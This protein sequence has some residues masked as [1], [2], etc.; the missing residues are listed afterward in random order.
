MTRIAAFLLMLALCGDALAQG[1]PRHWF[2]G[3]STAGSGRTITFIDSNRIQVS[4]RTRRAWVE[5]Y[6]DADLSNRGIRHMRNLNEYDCTQR[7]QRTLQITAYFVDASRS[8][9]TDAGE[10][11]WSY[12]VPG[13]AGEWELD[14]V[15]GS[16]AD[17]RANTRYV[18]I[19]NG[20]TTEEAAE[21]LFELMH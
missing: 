10:M 13:T 20:M 6:F 1:A 15:C 11:V 16:E 14:F 12:V 3:V 2:I 21:T 18:E 19:E 7:K 17:W 4:D 9:F 8:P 5:G